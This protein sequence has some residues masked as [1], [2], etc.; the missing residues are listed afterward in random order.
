MNDI[1]VVIAI[2]EY[3]NEANLGAIVGVVY[4]GGICE[5]HHLE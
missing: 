2:Y 1:R 5:Y 4:E 3:D